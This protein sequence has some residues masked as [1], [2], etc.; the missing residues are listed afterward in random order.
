VAE[1]MS[2]RGSMRGLMTL[3]T[4]DSIGSFAGVS[5]PAKIEASLKTAQDPYDRGR[6]RVQKPGNGSWTKKTLAFRRRKRWLQRQAR[7]ATRRRV[8]G[9]GV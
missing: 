3:L 4:F 7:K 8:R 6:Y 9:Y 2:N 1:R 5:W